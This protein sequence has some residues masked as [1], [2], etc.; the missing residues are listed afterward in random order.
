M[1]LSQKHQ[2]W[3]NHIN[4]CTDSG[5][6][7]SAYAKKHGLDLKQFY[8]IKYQFRKKGIVPKLE[9]KPIT[10][11]AFSKVVVKKAINT[12]NPVNH[13]ELIFSSGVVLRFDP[14]TPVDRIQSLAST[15]LGVSH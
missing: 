9:S 2:T 8:Q 7:M 3:L 13:C 5:I 15:L 12:E 1:K 6:E 10:S 11:P 14:N 4:Q